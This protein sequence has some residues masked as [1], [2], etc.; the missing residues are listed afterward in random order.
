MAATAVPIASEEAGDNAHTSSED[1]VLYFGII[2]ILQVSGHQP[3]RIHAGLYACIIVSI[4][5][6]VFV[7]WADDVGQAVTAMV[8]CRSTTC[9]SGL[10]MVSSLSAMMVAPFQQST[11]G[12]TPTASRIL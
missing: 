2:D 8:C 12:L 3:D 4:L 5:T 9:P 7:Q 1:V 6:T 11:L 10:S